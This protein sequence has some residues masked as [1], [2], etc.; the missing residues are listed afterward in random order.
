VWSRGVGSCGGGRGGE[1]TR[2][3]VAQADAL[4]FA[5]G[6]FDWVV[7]VESSHCYTSMERFVA[8]ASRVLKPGGFFVIAD[9]RDAD[10]VDAFQRQLSTPTLRV[11]RLHDITANVV[12]ALEHDSSRKEALIHRYIPGPF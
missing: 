3:A 11:V 10:E 12:W 5:S 8:E 9:F 1:T 7:N 6:R 2:V 4:T